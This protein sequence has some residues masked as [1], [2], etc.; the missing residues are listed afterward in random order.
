M[1][2]VLPELRSVLSSVHVLETRWE[3]AVPTGSGVLHNAELLA[4]A[5]SLE[6]VNPAHA[7][8]KPTAKARCLT[9]RVSCSLTR[10]RV[11][12]WPMWERTRPYVICLWT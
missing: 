2:T 7:P 8:G 1:C 9:K 10:T 11:A 3:P 6:L 4:L 12:A 5:T